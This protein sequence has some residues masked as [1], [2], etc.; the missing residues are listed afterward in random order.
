MSTYNRLLEPLRS[1]TMCSK[2]ISWLKF[3]GCITLVVPRPT[4]NTGLTTW[5]MSKSRSW[6]WKPTNSFYPQ[7]PQVRYHRVMRTV[8]LIKMDLQLS[9]RPKPST[10]DASISFIISVG[11]LRRRNRRCKT[12]RSKML[13][14]LLPWWLSQTHRRFKVAGLVCLCR[15]LVYR[16]VVC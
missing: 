14:K 1:G 2:T 15:L 10:T 13:A 3:M 4:G 16:V 12:T 11:R 5:W 8:L 7:D 6:G 9:C